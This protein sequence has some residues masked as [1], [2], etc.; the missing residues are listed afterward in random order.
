MFDMHDADGGFDKDMAQ[1]VLGLTLSLPICPMGYHIT[2]DTTQWQVF[3]D[4]VAVTICK[5]VRLRL[6]FHYGTQQ[7]VNCALMTHGIPVDTLPV[8]PGGGVDMTYRMQWIEYR[9]QQEAARYTQK[10]PRQS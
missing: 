6:R 5:F 9:Q 8:T 10:G 4:I 2:A 3:F 1:G 7:D